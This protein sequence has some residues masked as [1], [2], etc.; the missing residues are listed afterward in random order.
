MV[1][2]LI[3]IYCHGIIISLERYRHIYFIADFIVLIPLVV[4]RAIKTFYVRVVTP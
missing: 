2:K 4:S 3:I 1:Y